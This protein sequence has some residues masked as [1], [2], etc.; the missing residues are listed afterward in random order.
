MAEKLKIALFGSSFN[1]PHVGHVAVLEDLLAKN[2]FDG[3]WLLP[4][5]NH[6]FGKELVPFE[7]RVA[8]LKILIRDLGDMRVAFSEI[9]KEL[10]KSPSYSIDTVMELKR[11]HPDVE[12]HMIAGSDVKA[13]LDKWHRIAELKQILKFHFIPRLGY[14]EKSPYPKVSSSEIREKVKRGESLTGL[15]TPAIVEYITKRKLYS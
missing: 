1:P 8:M 6:A 4:V 10:G 2:L 11:R 9:E 15:T 7:E 5:Y 3:I 14:D 13:D 12:F